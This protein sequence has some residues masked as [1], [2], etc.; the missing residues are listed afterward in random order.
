MDGEQESDP[1]IVP[2][3]GLYQP[4]RGFGKLWRTNPH[5]RDGL[6]WAIAPEQGFHTQWQMQ[7][8]ESI[9]IPFYVRR[10]DGRIILAV[11]W[12]TALGTWQE[13]P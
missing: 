11:G 6:G 8:R 2:P 3:A 1:S 12:D 10:L 4:I 5:V 7:I 13:A 9:G